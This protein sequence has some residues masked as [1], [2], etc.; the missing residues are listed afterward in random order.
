[1][2]PDDLQGLRDRLSALDARI[3]E[4][5]AERT[6]LS[7]EIGRAKQAL[8]RGTRDFARE[9]VVLEKA[10]RRAADL[11][12]P[13]GLA[14]R[15]SIQLIEASL[16]AQEQ[17]R[18]S[19]T[20]SG[21]GQRALVV[22]GAGRMGRWFTTF[23]DT[24]GY[25]V[26]VADPHG[27]VPGLR[28]VSDWR[29]ADDDHDLVVVATPLGATNAVLEALAAR[30]PRGVVFDVGSLKTPLRPG[31]AA[32]REA[33]ARVTSL[34]PMFGPDTSL[35]S[36]RHV[37]F[38]DVGVPEATATARGLFQATMAELTDV[39]LDTHDRLIAFVLGLSHAT[40]LAFATALTASGEALPLLSSL[41]STT[42]DAQL[43]VSS[44][45]VAENAALYYEIQSLN[46]HGRLGLDALEEGVRTVRDLIDRGDADGFVEM[47]QR[48]RAY[49]AARTPPG[50][51]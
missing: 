8:G 17:D 9:R 36:G 40:N 35:L 21:D 23:L 42:F 30:P 4:L 37:L 2:D 15:L 48:G 1:M 14:E 29:D 7:L 10:R 38:V 44:R 27:A 6:A 19:G 50:R 46:D 49:L 25:E 11:G 12:L 41:S 47:M 22:G 51:G 45:V 32:L 5:V 33:G 26:D 3:L 39:D 43:G 24:Q 31:L 20:Q 34:H 18:V 13:P 16:S 28:C